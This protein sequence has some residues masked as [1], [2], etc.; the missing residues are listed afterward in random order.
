MTVS[1][2]V[3]MMAPEWIEGADLGLRRVVMMD[4]WK[5]VHWDD[6][7]EYRTVCEMAA[8]KVPSL[9]S[10]RDLLLVDGMGS[11]MADVTGEWTVVDLVD[12]MD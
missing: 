10:S 11:L 1:M 6:S 9:V 5:D 7:A 2:T 4:P 3:S 8:R 12:P